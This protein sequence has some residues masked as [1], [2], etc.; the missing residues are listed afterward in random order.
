MHELIVEQFVDDDNHNSYGAWAS[1]K[2]QYLNDWLN[3]KG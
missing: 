2:S 3:P 1:Q